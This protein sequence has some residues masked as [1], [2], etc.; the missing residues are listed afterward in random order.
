MF[1]Q[2]TVLDNGLTVVTERIDTVRS[3]AL[4]VWFRVG[5][6]DETSA[7]AGMSHFIE[8]M[9]FKGTPTRSAA[10]ISQ[11]FDRIGADLNAFTAKEYTC[12]YSRFV[13][14]NLPVVIDLFSDML[15]NSSLA[16]DACFRE[17]EVVLEEIAR[18]EDAPDDQIH[19]IFASGL[20]AGHPLGSSILGTRASVAGFDH[21]AT[22]AFRQKHYSPGNCIV[23]AAGLID[24]DE[25]VALVS[26]LLVLPGST[27]N[28]R[29]LSTPTS[30]KS[31]V[32]INK[33]TEQS[34]ICYGMTA[35]KWDHPD[36]YALSI[37][38]AVLGGGMSSRLFQ[39][40]RE[41][42]GLAYA[43][44]SFMTLFQ[45]TGQFAVYAGTRPA[46]TAEVVRI[47]RQQIELMASDGIS[48]AEL[49]RARNSFKG[50]L[51]L[52]LE[53][54]RARMSRLGKSFVVQSELLSIDELIGR[55]EAVTVDDVARV[56][57]SVFAAKGSLAFIGPLTSEEVD[58][59]SQ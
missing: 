26:S 34:H 28:T 51:V 10:D 14:D 56:V 22:A 55:I 35:L 25:L 42:K 27:I 20:Y 52:G 9:M 4:G 41:S 59:L 21:A 23:A 48:A 15:C 17:R 36:R 24:H 2:Q 44:Y 58:R 30:P 16:E 43:V 19:E 18:T 33:E 57:S 1:Y 47:I 5:S 8:H 45:E 38:D 53:D 11:A 12:Y 40:I 7:E 46:N 3:V 54:T 32:S 29:T 6:R 37:A 39:E 31:L 13:S 50:H 49:D